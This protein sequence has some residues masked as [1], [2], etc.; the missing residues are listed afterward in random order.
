MY[1]QIRTAFCLKTNV[2]GTIVRVIPCNK[3]CDLFIT[4]MFKREE[5]QRPLLSD[6]HQNLISSNLY[7]DAI[8]C[9]VSWNSVH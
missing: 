6:M 8:K 4:K 7:K 9:K 2:L 3:S 5:P 1:T